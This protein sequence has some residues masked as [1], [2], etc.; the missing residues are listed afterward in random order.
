MLIF[1]LISFY[2]RSTG[3]DRQAYEKGENHDPRLAKNRRKDDVVGGRPKRDIGGQSLA[4][5]QSV[6][7]VQVDLNE[8]TAKFE[9]KFANFTETVA[10]HFKRVEAHIGALDERF[11]SMEIRLN[12]TNGRFDGL[13]ERLNR[14]ERRLNETE[15]RTE[16]C[17]EELENKIQQG[18]G[19][20]STPG[21]LLKSTTTPAPTAEAILLLKHVWDKD[22]DSDSERKDRWSEFKDGFGAPNEKFFWLGLEKIHRMTSNGRWTLKVRVKYDRIARR[23]GHLREDPKAGTF[24]EAEWDNFDVGKEDAELPYQLTVGELINE[25]NFGKF[26]VWKYS[27][28]QAFQ[29]RDRETNRPDWVYYRGMGGG[30]WLGRDGTKICLTC[31]QWSF[32]KLS[33]PSI[34]LQR[35]GPRAGYDFCILSEAYMWM[36]PVKPQL[37]F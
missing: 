36:K 29:T 21:E 25:T 8:W 5:V 4:V 33:Y 18:S 10:K 7:P 34:T 19:T 2:H 15:A 11:G 12:E 28:K 23:D 37:D 24:G 22:G 35:D 14:L 32:A 16:E 9:R 1:V 17:H 30:W 20:T 26:R 3:E 6:F 27:N 31:T 13:Q